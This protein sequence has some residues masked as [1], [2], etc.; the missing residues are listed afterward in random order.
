[1]AAVQRRRI[2]AV[3]WDLD[4]TLLDTETLSS[5]AI[6]L[7]LSDYGATLDWGLKKTLMG[8]P[9]TVWPAMVVEAYGLHGRLAPTDLLHR[10]ESNLVGM[11]ERIQKMDGALEAVSHLFGLQVPMAVATSSNAESVMKKAMHHQDIF[12]KMRVVVAGNDPAVNQGKPAPD[13]FLVA[14]ER[15]GVLDVSKCLIF[16]DSLAGVEAA[17]RAGAFCVAVPDARL[18]PGPF[19]SLFA[20]HDG[21]GMLRASLRDVDWA[22][23]DFDSTT[24]VSD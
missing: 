11:S 2:S 16:E 10:W 1:M 21:R 12:G 23:F 3:L 24:T 17:L 22:A 19:Q 8:L 14:A 18:D 9:G 5:E 7:V 20:R 13:I 15:L 6:Q 4:G